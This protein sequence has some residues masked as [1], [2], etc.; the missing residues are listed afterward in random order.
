M[1]KFKKIAWFMDVN[2]ETNIRNIFGKHKFKGIKKIITT[3]ENNSERYIWNIKKATLEDLIEFNELYKQEIGKKYN[4]KIYDLINIYEPQILSWNNIYFSYL[5][6]NN[7]LIAWWISS[8]KISRWKDTLA[9]CIKVWENIKIDWISILYYI[10]YLFFT[11][12]MKLNVKQFSAGK[13]RNCYGYIWENIWLAIH[14]LQN[15]YLPYESSDKE[16]FEIEEN[17]ILNETMLLI[18]NPNKNYFCDKAILRS[19]KDNIKIDEEFV[20][21]KKRWISLEIRSL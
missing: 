8:H 12:G 5:R 16:E 4:S 18:P 10:E 20:L 3:I 9:G 21:L 15:H 17:D 1:I 11:L 2:E 7:I 13:D 19:N 14:K 6:E